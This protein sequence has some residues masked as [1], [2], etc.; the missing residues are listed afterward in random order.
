[1][2]MLHRIRG[3]VMRIDPHTVERFDELYDFFEPG[4][5]LD[6][7]GRLQPFWDAATP[8]TFGRA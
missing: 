5:L 8:Q 7:A 2:E 1:M 6:G 3:Y 4:Q